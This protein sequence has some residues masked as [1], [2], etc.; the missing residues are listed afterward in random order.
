MVTAPVITVCDLKPPPYPDCSP[1]AHL[2]LRLWHPDLHMIHQVGLDK[3]DCKGQSPPTE[4]K[5][6][7]R[8]SLNYVILLVVTNFL[9]I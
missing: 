1:V 8:Q 4:S 3:A 6:L 9:V 2:D 7:I 5:V